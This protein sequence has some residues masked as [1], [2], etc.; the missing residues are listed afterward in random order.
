M[1]KNEKPLSSMDRAI[2][3]AM[4]EGREVGC[5]DDPAKDR[6]P[7]LWEWMTKIYA[8]RE[9]MMQPATLTIR[10]VSGGVAVSCA[11]RDLA[12]SISATTPHLI[13]ALDAI[14][15]ALANPLTP[16]AQWGRKEP[17]LRKRR[18]RQ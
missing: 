18:L 10:M 13:D 16:M 15:T 4:G 11:N 8:G 5:A 6:W 9:H 1:A 12:T 3:Q 2:L 7:T 14:E 17:Q